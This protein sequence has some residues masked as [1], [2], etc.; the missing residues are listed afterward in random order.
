MQYNQSIIDYIQEGLKGTDNIPLLSFQGIFVSKDKFFKDVDVF[1]RYLNSIGIKRGDTVT[2]CLP[3]FVSAVVAFYAINKVGAKIA[4]LHPLITASGLVQEIKKTNSKLL[5]Y[6]DRFYTKNHQELKNIKTVVVSATDYL[7]GIQWLGM[8]IYNSSN[9][10][11]IK[12]LPD[13]FNKSVEFYEDII[14]SNYPSFEEIKVSGE[15][16]CLYLPS[17]GTTGIPKTIEITNYALNSISDKIIK[18][19][20]DITS[21]K[22]SMLMVLPIFHGFGIAVCMHTALSNGI[23]VVLVPAFNPKKINRIIKTEKVSHIAGVPA[24]YEKLINCKNFKGKHLS[25]I[26]NAYCGGDVL[27]SGIKERY[28]KTVAKYGGKSRLLQGYGLAES[29]AV[30]TCNTLKYEKEGSIGRPM[31]GIKVKIIDEDGNT[32]R[33]NVK[34]ELCISGDT[35]MKS[36][37]KEDSCESIFTDSEGVKWLKTGDYGYIDNEGYVFFAG[38]KKRIIIISGINVFPYEIEREVNEFAEI[39]NSSAIETI[40]EGKT[41]IRLYVELNEGYILDNALKSKI[42]NRLK[43]KFMKYYIPKDIVEYNIPL[44]TIGKIDFNKLMEID[45]KLFI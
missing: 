29:I 45:K 7:N 14:K 28:D 19:T 32:L 41:A 4:V 23:R 20:G 11:S 22:D 33:E 35:L 3:N 5:I 13:F 17:G 27:A 10:K 43:T 38:R 1:A 24:M 6:F 26:M 39:K 40:I 9:N 18:L 8:K 31:D 36:Y 15:E 30:C 25:N 44:T 34:G 42:I 2:I 12:K 37:Y 21:G 16:V